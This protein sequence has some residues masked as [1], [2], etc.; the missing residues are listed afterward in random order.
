MLSAALF[1]S[2]SQEVQKIGNVAAE[3]AEGATHAAADGAKKW[4]S[5]RDK[6]VALGTIGATLGAQRLLKDIKTGEQ[7]H[8]A[9]GGGY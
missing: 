4:L 8:K 7:V 1:E 9:Q 6:V 2:F 5:G 3:A